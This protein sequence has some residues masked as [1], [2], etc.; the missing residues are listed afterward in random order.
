MDKTN[1]LST[2]MVIRSPN[3]KKNPFCPCKDNEDALDPEVS[4]LSASGAL[5]HL[6]NC[7]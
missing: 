2:P 1:T 6:A 4:Y 7:T 5:M 3:V